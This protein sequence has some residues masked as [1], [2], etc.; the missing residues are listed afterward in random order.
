MRPPHMRPPHLRQR[1]TSSAKTRARS[2]AQPMR[3]TCVSLRSSPTPTPS[4]ASYTAPALRLRLLLPANSCCSPDRARVFA[5]DVTA[6][7]AAAGCVSWRS[8]PTPTPSPESST[9][10]AL[11]Q[12]LLPLDS[13]CCSPD[14]ADHAPHPATCLHPCAPPPPSRA[15]GRA[16]RLADPHSRFPSPPRPRQHRPPAP[17]A[18]SPP[19]TWPPKFSL[20]TA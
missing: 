14:H 2:L 6:A 16:L 10:P 1:V 5:L 15:H 17:P 20:R 12:H 18:H 7:S 19:L 13:S 3:R 11:R 8:S 9:A 4:P